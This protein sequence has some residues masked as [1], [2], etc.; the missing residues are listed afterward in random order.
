MKRVWHS[1]DLRLNGI[2]VGTV[3]LGVLVTVTAWSFLELAPSALLV[4][5]HGQRVVWRARSGSPG[6][7]LNDG[8]ERLYFLFPA[9]RAVLAD[10]RGPAPPRSVQAARAADERL[11]QCSLPPGGDLAEGA[12]CFAGDPRSQWRQYCQVKTN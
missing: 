2:V 9:L 4:R 8:G 6:D 1:S 3:L 10:Q 11:Q 7:A 12:R 5:R